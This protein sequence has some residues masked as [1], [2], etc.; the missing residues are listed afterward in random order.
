MMAS[1][2]F[3]RFRCPLFQREC[4]PPFFEFK[5]DCRSLIVRQIPPPQL[6]RQ[7]PD[8]DVFARGNHNLDRS[9]FDPSP[10][11]YLMPVMPVN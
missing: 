3:A 4:R 11:A 6:V 5:G 8:N 2:R 1:A 9:V 7:N 10:F